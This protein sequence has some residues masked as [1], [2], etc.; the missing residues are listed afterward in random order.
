ML[1]PNIPFLIV[2]VLFFAGRLFDLLSVTDIATGYMSAAPVVS[3]PLM[4]VLV[5]IVAACCTVFVRPRLINQKKIK[6][7]TPGIFGAF[8][9]AFL[10]AA[11]VFNIINTFK[12]GGFLGFDI[13][14][15]L[16][17]VSLIFLSFTDIKGKKYETLPFILTVAAFASVCLNSVIIDIGT[18]NNT[19]YFFK[20]IAFI[21]TFIFVLLLFKSIYAP[22]KYTKMSLYFVSLVNFVFSCLCMLALL[23]AYVSKLGFEPRV[24]FLYAGY[25]SMGLYSMTLAFSLTKKTK[26]AP[27]RAAREIEPKYD[28]EPAVADREDITEYIPYPT[29]KEPAP[30]A[31]YNSENE[32]AGDK[33]ADITALFSAN[34]AE[35]EPETDY[36]KE[37]QE[38]K[39]K[40]IRPVKPVKE[41]PKFDKKPS[42]EPYKNETNGKKVFKAGRRPEKSRQ[43]KKIVYKAD[44]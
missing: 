21:N 39:Q 17:S 37:N 23:V 6:A 13:A 24:V 29:E 2:A 34:F 44:K 32:S 40:K 33:V 4:I 30:A 11:A 7:R 28:Y 1:I 9:G 18:V 22:A 3:K 36:R 15:I 42:K 27:K 41:K 14:I 35:K 25:I 5:F 10:I 38:K 16:G 19:I 8:T 20:N 31:I 12:W 26:T 43:S